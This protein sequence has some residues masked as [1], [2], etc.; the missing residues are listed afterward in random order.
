MGQTPILRCTS[1]P[2]LQPAPCLCPPFTRRV[3][4]AACLTLAH[5]G[6]PS[7]ILGKLRQKLSYILKS[8]SMLKITPLPYKSRHSW[9]T[10]PREGIARSRGGCPLTQRLNLQHKGDIHFG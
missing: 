8:T 6:L 4:H 5:P 2:W 1:Q 7:E 10:Q 9:S 3:G